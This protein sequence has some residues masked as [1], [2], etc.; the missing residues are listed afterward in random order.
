MSQI[1]KLLAVADSEVGYLEK[2]SNAQLDEKTA[3][4]GSGNFTKYWC[5]LKPSYQGLAW[6]Y[7]F[8][9]WC[10]RRAGVGEDVAPNHY[11]CDAGMN[12]YKAR[13]QFHATPQRGDLIY[14]GVPGDA[15][16][17]GIVRDVRSTRVY[18]YEGN[19][20]G[21][22]TMIANGGSVAAKDYALNYAKIL[23]YG[24]PNYEEDE[25]SEII[26]TLAAK[27]GKTE[28]AVIDGLAVLLKHVNLTEEAWEKDGARY[29]LDEGL[30]TSPR[31]GN[32]PV[33]FGELG[34]ILR[35]LAGRCGK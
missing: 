14:F 13:G 10:L 26:K 21:G 8:V 11:D 32:E 4:A 7:C 19:T 18:T 3:N 23:G 35:N 17:V 25:M 6:C 24:R 15:Q 30:I 1:D 34:V 9:S 16:H 20:S 33:E 2:R 12:W 27:S 31:V 22:S 5:D 28:A 29:L